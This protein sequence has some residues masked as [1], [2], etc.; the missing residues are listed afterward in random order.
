LK[1]YYNKLRKLN[2]NTKII[3]Q[4]ILDIILIFSAITIV[5]IVHLDDKIF[6]KN[7]IFLFLQASVLIFTLILF[8][9]FG[10]YR[11]LVRHLTTKTLF[12]VFKGVFFSSIIFYLG[13]LAIFGTFPIIAYGSYGIIL[14]I[15]ISSFRFLVRFIFRYLRNINK[16]PVLIYG[17]GEEGLQ[18]L[19]LL[20]HDKDYIPVGL[21]D[22]DPKLFK[23]TIAGLSVSSPLQ[24]PKLISKTG[25][26]VLLLAIPN[27]ER[28]FLHKLIIEL[29][30][31]PI[32]IKTIPAMSDIIDG[33]A[34]ITE[35]RT[36]EAEDL[37]GRVP[38]EPNEMLME[39]NT[40][41]KN[42]MVS[43]AGGTI[44]SEL[45]RQILKRK[46]SKIVL[47]ESSEFAL[48]KIENEL[49]E[50]INTLD[51]KSKI[52]SILGSVRNFDQLDQLIK[53]YDVQ[54]IYHAAAYKHVP[55][56]EDNILESVQNNV[57]GT[58][59]I[60]AAAKKNN[61]QNFILISTDKAVRPTN[62]MGATKRIAELICQAESKEVSNT[63]F[64]MVRFGNVLGSSGSV[65]P[66][67]TEQIKKGGPLSLT[68]PEI[69]RY[70]MT[71]SEASQLVI[72]AGALAKGGDVF[73]LDM[74]NP[75]KMIDL[76]QSMIIMSGLTPVVLKDTDKFIKIAG[77]IPIQII[78]LRKGEKLY[79]ELLIGTDSHQTEHPKI[80]TANEY[81]IQKDE[82]LLSIKDL[83]A[84]YK[85]YDLDKT[86][87]IL[88]NL[89]INYTPFKKI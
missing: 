61:V 48:Y 26:E 82:L 79:E 12:V 40:F 86:L 30:D 60:V 52:I 62:V 67:F 2:R 3:I 27:L 66:K 21:I 42:V 84:A 63:I 1:K 43:G 55:L 72:Q 58:Q 15:L 69:T 23:L 68:H 83:D 53:K 20:Y 8:W 57:F 37:L 54:I 33:S 39:K 13:N 9:S 85:K 45:C 34:K 14:F 31:I 76:A 50:L 89:P 44:G 81:F 5:S 29:K 10:L 22:D 64:S 51:F 11:I 56:V 87:D 75:V 65:I 25:A 47:F 74:G 80:L 28:S 88:K 24:I 32:K 71:I 38:I 73:V 6:I 49:N 19:N 16:R 7:Y 70:F 4:I 18:L 77:Q 41:N 78:G 35:L 36:L 17:A 46:P 59:K